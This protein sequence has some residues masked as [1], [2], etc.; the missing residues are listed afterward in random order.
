ML[1]DLYQTLDPIAFSIGPFTA[2]WYGI[3]YALGFILAAVVIYFVGKR[4]KMR[5]DM[6]SICTIIICAVVGVIIGG[7][8]G[9]VLVY[10]G[11]FYAAHPLEI[12]NFS[13]GGMSFHGGL[14]GALL[15]GIVAARLV[16]MP[17][18]SLVDVAIIGVPIGLFF[19]RCA[20]FVNGE[21]WGAV[22]DLPWGVVFGGSAG[23]EPRHPSQLYE[24]TLEG[25]VLFCVLFAMSLKKPP[26][27]QGTY[28]G[29]FFLGY[30]VFRFLVEFIRQPDLQIGYLFGDW[31]TMGQLL[32]LPLVIAGIFLLLYA[33]VKKRPQVGPRPSENEEDTHETAIL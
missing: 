31:F 8:L 5:F 23:L 32:S 12:L 29:A 14:V 13:N 28:I 7:R 2:R 9:Y 16:K 4:W 20:N 33:Y 27:P 17:Y 15:A 21:L 6:S 19:G 30:G 10:N 24:A 22:T 25:L 11:A 26:F 1:N 3:A 18:L